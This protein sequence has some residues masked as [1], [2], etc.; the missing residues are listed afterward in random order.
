VIAVDHSGKH[1]GFAEGRSNFELHEV[2]LDKEESAEQFYK[3]IISLKGRIDTAVFLVGGYMP[4]GIGQ[5]DG[6]ALKKMLNLNFGT[7]YF[8]VRPVFRHMTNRNYGRIVLMGAKTALDPAGGKDA[9][10]YTLS[11]SLMFTLADLLNATAADK[12]VRLSVVAPGALDTP[13]NREAMP[14][15]TLT[16]TETVAEEIWNLVQ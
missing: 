1:L 2:D 5:T 3:E 6:A 15:A 16:K 10:A 8:S 12:D 14:D 9:L 11:K 13:V 4:G 7:S